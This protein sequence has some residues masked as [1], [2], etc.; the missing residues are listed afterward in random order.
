M[1]KYFWFF[2][3]PLFVVGCESI[4]T[5]EDVD[6]VKEKVSYVEKDLYSTSKAIASKFSEVESDY[7]EKIDNL[8]SRIDSIKKDRAALVEQ[9]SSLQEEINTLKGKIDETNFNM[10]KQFKQQ[11][12]KIEDYKIETKRDI[13]GLKKTYN[14]IIKSISTLNNSITLIQ[15]DLSALRKSQEEIAKNLE[16]LSGI[17][18]KNSLRSA[19]I[20][21]KVNKNSRVFLDELTRQESEIYFLKSKISRIEKEGTLVE[22]GTGGG[23]Y[24]I[25][26]KGDYLGKIARKYNTSVKA[27]KRANKLKSDIIYPGQ[28]LIIP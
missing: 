3:I 13:D 22:T 26:K 2:V 15:K 25:V 20:E 21:E 4:A 24:Y 27:I 18:N 11:N 19:Q 9:I 23:K 10:D 5:K 1:R 14:D 16:K 28:K 6:T 17:V 7:N 8:N 12:D